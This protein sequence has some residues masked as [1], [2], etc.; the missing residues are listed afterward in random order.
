VKRRDLLRAGACATLFPWLRR[1]WADPAGRAPPLVLLMQQNGVG[2]NG[3][4]PEPGLAPEGTSLAP[5]LG[6]ARLRARTTVIKGLY[7]RDGGAG[8]QHDWGFAGLWSGYRTV[9]RGIDPW[10]GGISI[11]QDLRARLSLPEP[12]PTLACGV[13]A[14]D[15]SPVKRHRVS[16]SYLGARRPLPIETD[17]HKLYARFFPAPVGA[18]G[19]AD[20]PALAAARLRQKRSVLD[21]VAGDLRGLRARIGG[22]GREALDAHEAALRAYERGLSATLGPRDG[23]ADPRCS[24]PHA[25]TAGLD[26]RREDDAPV[27]VRLMLDFVALAI[28]CGLTRIVTYQFG[29]GG[30]RW[31]YRWLGIDQ[32][33]HDE[34]AHRD[35]GRDDDVTAKMGKIDRWHAEQ[36]ARLARAL[37]AMPGPS[38]TLL[39]AALVAWGNELALGPHVLDGIPV[40]LVGGAGGRLRRTGHLVDEGPQDYHRLGT[41]LLRIMGVPAEGFGEAGHCGPLAGLDLLS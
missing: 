23:A 9:G 41:S 24:G 33:A 34:I 5:L 32:N 38:G 13:L 21:Y 31:Y 30:E 39:D 12:F 6:D 40:V 36:V 25:D 2:R 17:P 27:L 14:S 10:G 4:W 8:N 20:A 26:L 7:N 16:F 29:A 22:P 28:G 37:D 18:R 35:F 19:A 15:T 11:D 1:A 3:F